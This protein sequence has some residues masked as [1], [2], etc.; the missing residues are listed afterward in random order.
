MCDQRVQLQDQSLR[1][2]S[3]KHME[4]DCIAKELHV[5]VEQAGCELQ[6]PW[7]YMLNMLQHSM[8]DVYQELHRALLED[9]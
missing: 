6:S 3:C 5:A 9:G 1:D 2:S 4:A 7:G 8:V